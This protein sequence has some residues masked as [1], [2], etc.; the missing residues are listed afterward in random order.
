MGLITLENSYTG[1]YRF[2]I[3]DHGISLTTSEYPQWVVALH[4]E[5]Y[6][7]E[8]E[9]VWVSWADRD[10]TD[11]TAYLVL[12]GKEQK[13]IFHCK[14]IEKAVGWDGQSWRSLA[15][16]DLSE[17]KVQ[18]RIE[19]NTYNETTTLRVTAID[20]YDAEPGR[21]VR[22]LDASEVK[23]LDARFASFFRK[24]KGEKKPV[25]PVGKPVVPGKK[26]IA[27]PKVEVPAPEE[28]PEVET[29]VPKAPKKTGKTSKPKKGKGI[30]QGDAWKACKKAK[31]PSVSE[32]KLAELWLN[33]VEK[34]AP[35]GDEEQMSP[36]LWERVRDIVCEQ[37][38]GEEVAHL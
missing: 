37:V 30:S 35:D 2:S 28:T 24:R 9:K 11:I 13:E 38:S 26:S 3:I 16:L 21:T 8:E 29:D 4:A 23:D 19:E 22:K 15:E 18:G 7:D 5:A 20:H 10:D 34:L 14:S 32:K 25:K 27:K 6:W 31:D 17:V 33:T 1:T 36:E 12:A